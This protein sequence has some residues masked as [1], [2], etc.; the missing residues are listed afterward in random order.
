MRVI[1]P[2]VTDLIAS[3]ISEDLS[4][5]STATSYAAG[6]QVYISISDFPN[7]IM[8]GDCFFNSFTT[9]G[10]EWTYS[11]A[12]TRYDCDGSQ[13]GVSKLYQAVPTS[14]IVAG[15]QFLVQFEVSAF[16]AGT[17]T[18]YVA[19][20][21][22]ANVG[23]VGYYQQLIL[24]GST[25]AFVGVAVS[26][27][28]VGSITNILVKK[29][30]VNCQNDI[31]ES[32]TTQS[33]NFPPIDDYTNWVRRSAS[34]RWKMFDDYTSTQS[35]KADIIHVKVN[36][37]KCDALAL[38][39]V[40]GTTSRFILTENS[41]SYAGTSSTSVAIG[42]GVKSFTAST[43][44]LWAVDD[45]VE[46]E[47]TVD[48]LKFMVGT[49]TAYNSATGA[50]DV[51]V[52]D[53]Q[54][55]G[56]LS[57][58]AIRF[59]YQNTEYDLTLSESISWSDYFFTEI[60]FM[61]STTKS[62]PLS[63]NS[64]CRVILTGATNQVIRCGHMLVGNGKYLG[65]TQNGISAGITDYSTEETN[66]YGETYLSQGAFAKKLNFDIKIAAGSEDQVFDI[67]SQVR[68]I[69]CAWDAN[70]ESTDKSVMVVYG[71]YE[72]FTEL[73]K[74]S[75]YTIISIDIKGLI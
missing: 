18:G 12:N 33:G 2:K 9:G 70:N 32:Q 15:D 34:I 10:A 72:D 4:A 56:T 50:L 54:G 65:K 7:L 28:F 22:G 1:I 74:R 41:S 37:T 66:A 45:L 21:S 26:S 38:F 51:T 55:S 13:A 19:G 68:S 52:T 3:N 35:E 39:G 23:A 11:A 20:T 57:A 5:W 6:D 17:A 64:Y 31:Y 69:P 58:W 62:F 8:N 63:Y 46:I 16:T 73:L 60:R 67:L 14:K 27:T 75:N 43:G 61:S 24:A 40:E 49:V 47:D 25:D 29:T 48:V 30:G 44:K 71:I 42:T 53:Y 36:S 59:C